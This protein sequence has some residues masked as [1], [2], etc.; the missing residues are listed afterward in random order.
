LH[1]PILEEKNE[2]CTHICGSHRANCKFE[3]DHNASHH[4]PSTWALAF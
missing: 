2:P 3:W 4:G 1:L